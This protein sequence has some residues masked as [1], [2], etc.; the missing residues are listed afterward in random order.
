[1]MNQSKRIGWFLLVLAAGILMGGYLFDESQPRSFLSIHRCQD[2]LNAK[3][4][5]GL[6]I[7]VGVQKMPGLL[8]YVIVETPKTV[9]IRNPRPESKIDFIII[10][11]KD[12]RNIAEFSPEDAPYLVD[13]YLVARS[14][15]EREKLSNY[16]LFTN[17]PGFQDAT[18]LH[19]HLTGK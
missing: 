11:K 2:C 16:R 4:L 10:P 12:L 1:M 19:F 5:A 9:A 7:S 17:G 14:I 13:A 6:L 18:Y 8:P 3:D 15:I